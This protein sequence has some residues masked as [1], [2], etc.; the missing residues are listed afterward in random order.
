MCSTA[1]N[2]VRDCASSLPCVWYAGYLSCPQ[3]TT[4]GIFSL[5]TAALLMSGLMNSSLK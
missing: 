5:G 1:I 4:E 3:Y 2:L